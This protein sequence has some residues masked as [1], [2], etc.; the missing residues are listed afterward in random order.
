MCRSCKDPGCVLTGGVLSHR[1]QWSRFQ[2]GLRPGPSCRTSLRPSSD[3]LICW[4]G[5]PIPIYS[6]PSTNTIPISLSGKKVGLDV[7]GQ[8]VQANNMLATAGNQIHYLWISI[9]TFHRVIP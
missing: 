2:P 6:T 1:K 8:L 5:I 7:C 3:L 9:Q 4:E